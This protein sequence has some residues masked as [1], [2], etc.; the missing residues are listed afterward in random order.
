MNEFK[1][2]IDTMYRMYYLEFAH[3]VLKVKNVNVIFK[4]NN[5]IRKKK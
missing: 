3:N 4:Y 1:I 2:I 5:R